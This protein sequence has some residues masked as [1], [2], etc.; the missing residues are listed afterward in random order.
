MKAVVFIFIVFVSMMPAHAQYYYN[1]STLNVNL[2]GNVNVYDAARMRE[3]EVKEKELELKRRQ[4]ELQRKSEKLQY[5]LEM[6]DRDKML[7]ADALENN[8]GKC[9]DFFCGRRCQKRASNQGFCAKHY[10]ERTKG[11]KDGKYR[12]ISN[13]RYR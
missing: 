1:N 8:D 9:C 12:M 7:E 11:E 10:R 13:A 2:Q 5:E 3:A 6:K 4:L